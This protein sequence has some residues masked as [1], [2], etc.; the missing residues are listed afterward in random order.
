[1]S[2]SGVE[3]DEDSYGTK[4]RLTASGQQDF[5]QPAAPGTP[6]YSGGMS[7]LSNLSGMAGNRS[8][9]QRTSTAASRNEP[10][11]VQFLMRHGIAKSPL[12]GQVILIVIV[13]LNIIITYVVIKYFL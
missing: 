7:G 11:M 2:S 1:M 4:P 13:V 6:G 10:K 12:T 9:P 3:F 8:S 5:H